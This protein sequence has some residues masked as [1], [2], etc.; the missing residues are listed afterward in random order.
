LGNTLRV[1]LYFHYYLKKMNIPSNMFSQS[2]DSF[3]MVSG[4]DVCLWLD[5]KHLSTFERRI[6]EFVSP[7]KDEKMHGLG[8][9]IESY[10]IGKWWSFD[11]CSK[12]SVML[13]DKWIISRD[14][15]KM[16]LTSQHYKSAGWWG[17]G[18]R[19]WRHAMSDMFK[20][21]CWGPVSHLLS[22]SYSEDSIEGARSWLHPYGIDCPNKIPVAHEASLFQGWCKAARLSVTEGLQL[23]M[24]LVDH[25]IITL[26][27]DYLERPVYIVEPSRDKEEH[28]VCLSTCK[29][30]TSISYGTPPKGNNYTMSGNTAN[31]RNK[32]KK[33][34]KPS[35]NKNLK[36]SKPARPM[37]KSTRNPRMRNVQKK[38]QTLSN[39]HHSSGQQHRAHMDYMLPDNAGKYTQ[40]LS[41]HYNKGGFA[42]FDLPKDFSQAENTMNLARQHPGF[43][44]EF[45]DHMSGLTWPSTVVAGAGSIAP[46]Y[47]AG[48]SYMVFASCLSRYW[49]GFTSGTMIQ[50]GDSM[51]TTINFAT[52]W[53]NS[54]TGI[55]R[56]TYST[57]S[58]FGGSTAE[59][60]TTQ[61]GGFWTVKYTF[62]LGT[63]LADK[64]SAV[65]IGSIPYG[66]SMTPTNLVACAEYS[67]TTDKE[68][69]LK[70]FIG[71]P[72]IASATDSTGIGK[73]LTRERI[74]YWI[75]TNPLQTIG[76]GTVKPSIDFS[77]I[78]NVTWMPDYTNTI[79]QGISSQASRVSYA[80][81]DNT[82]FLDSIIEE[83]KKVWNIGQKA[84]GLISNLGIPAL[85]KYLPLLGSKGQTAIK[86]HHPSNRG[87]S[88]IMPSNALKLTASEELPTADVD[89]MK[90]FITK[91]L[92]YSG[93]LPGLNL[94]EYIAESKKALWM[95]ENYDPTYAVCAY[96]FPDY[97][98]D[99]WTWAIDNDL[100]IGIP[101]DLALIIN[102]FA[103]NME[104]E[105][106]SEHSKCDMTHDLHLRGYNAKWDEA[107]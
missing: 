63:V 14:Q 106:V 58:M 99:V 73:T 78:G 12:N 24:G 104:F 28:P 44:S 72:V 35:K 13:G 85:F 4:D 101:D 70:D 69:I 50:T 18:R 100:S 39:A 92:A 19:R 47:Y 91:F 67:S 9:C 90:R 2:K 49:Q 15:Q 52:D 27:F 88:G 11:F 80:K 105:V 6:Y 59:L 83:G 81:E 65:Y 20:Y 32:G 5:K 48:T 57:N 94:D 97:I 79:T 64:G 103:T 82:S 8:Q 61:A 40:N 96:H 36:A 55:D 87:P 33:P 34:A 25:S 22:K 42:T 75:I 98:E 74:V 54:T 31:N 16:L 60:S 68:W 95:V 93:S 38:A 51:Y 56:T 45:A 46:D 107:H 76:D 62:S 23:V 29:Y 77:Y 7:D 86:N 10:Q 84:V 21:E 41:R 66:A 37:P 3:I 1:L 26:P 17:L 89:E 53:S 43:P 102:H 71:S 30:C